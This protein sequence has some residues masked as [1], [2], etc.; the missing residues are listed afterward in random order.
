MLIPYKNNRTMYRCRCCLAIVFLLYCFL[1]AVTYATPA[2]TPPCT[3]A[4][5][6]T[7]TTYDT[8]GYDD[9]PRNHADYDNLIANYANDA[10]QF[11]SGTIATINGSGNP[12]GADENYLSIFTGYIYAPTTGDYVFA[13][14]G[15]DAVEVI[16]DGQVL[17][18]WYGAHARRGAPQ[19]PG[20]INLDQGYHEIIFNH[21]EYWGQDNYYLYW[22]RPGDASLTI[23]NSSA[24]FHCPPTT[25]IDLV[26]TKLTVSDPVNLTVNP[27]T[28]PGAIVRFTLMATNTG[29]ITADNSVLSDNLDDLITVK[30][31][32]LWVMNSMTITAPDVMAGATTPLTDAIDTD[33]GQFNDSPGDRVVRVNCGSLQSGQ[34]CRVTFDVQI[35]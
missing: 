24:L 27:K 17:S 2:I 29:A 5:G 4:S 35:N 15:D 16:V 7:H 26:K 32:A 20:T 19:N 18:A 14:D 1:T 21:Q 22:Q 34:S 10:N 31:S 25:T 11:G 33:V 30:Q 13:V 9:W 3:P 28:I 23:V 6:L 12:F 8:T